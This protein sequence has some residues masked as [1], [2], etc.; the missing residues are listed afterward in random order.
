VCDIIYK[1]YYGYQNGDCRT[2]QGI[3]PKD[4]IVICEE[5]RF[6]LNAIEQI[7]YSALHDRM[8]AIRGRL[9]IDTSWIEGEEARIPKFKQGIIFLAVH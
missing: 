5:I 3:G 7:T 1:R 8:M 2:C 6:R 4:E 9:R